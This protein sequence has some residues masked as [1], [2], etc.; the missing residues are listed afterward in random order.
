MIFNTIT[1]WLWKHLFIEKKN[2][3]IIDYIELW[4]N[5]TGKTNKKI[6]VL[7]Q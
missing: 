4:Y 3:L 5:S 1:Y 6:I 7:Y 2:V